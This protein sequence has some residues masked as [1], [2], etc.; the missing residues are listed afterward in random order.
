MAELPEPAGVGIDTVEVGQGVDHHLGEL[1]VGFR[2]GPATEPVGDDTPHHH[3][4]ET[5]H[6][7]ELGADH[8]LVVAEGQSARR[9]VERLP[10]SGEDSILPTH[11]MGA[12]G[13]RAQGRPPED[14]VGAVGKGQEVREVGLAPTELGHRRRT[15]RDT[16]HVGEPGGETGSRRTSRPA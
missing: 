14:E 13:D 1:S 7:Q 5:L 15:L 6:Q 10:E 16:G 11:V 3:P 2:V 9:L 8:A 12:G 4:V